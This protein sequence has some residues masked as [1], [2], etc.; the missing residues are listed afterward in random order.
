MHTARKLSAMLIWSLVAACSATAPTPTPNVSPISRPTS[1]PTAAVPATE[2]P[3]SAGLS[4]AT[5]P[6]ATRLDSPEPTQSSAEPSPPM[7]PS[8]TTA[9]TATPTPGPTTAP[10]VILGKVKALS[11]AQ[12]AGNGIGGQVALVFENKGATWIDGTADFVLLDHAGHVTCPTASIPGC[13]Y[14][15]HKSG[16]VAPGAVGYV[17]GDLEFGDADFKVSQYVRADATPTLSVHDPLTDQLIFA[18]PAYRQAYCSASLCAGQPWGVHISL[19]VTNGGDSPNHCT[20]VSLAMLDGEGNPI[21]FATGNIPHLPVGG[22]A[23]VKFLQADLPH[24]VGDIA[25]S[26]AYPSC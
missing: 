24:L 8:P 11:L 12:Y 17:W 5:T 3:T 16:P 6:M 25:K 23:I 18:K 4:P 10:A 1:V 9:P 13:L 22:T 7:T 20:G 14:Q 2:A 21:G 26:V 19:S 15:I